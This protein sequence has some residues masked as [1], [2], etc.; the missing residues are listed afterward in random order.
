MNVKAQV[1][2]FWEAAAC[3][4]TYAVGSALRGQLEAQA[5]ARYELEPYLRPF[6]GFTDGHRK[7]VLEIGVGMGADHLAWAQAQPR[8][9]AGI[10]LTDRAVELTQARLDAAKLASTLAVADA[11]RLPFPDERF[12][13]IY[14]W[15]VL[16]H[17]PD[18]L[19]AFQEVY[20]VLRPAGV[21]RLMIYHRLSLTVLMLWLRYGLLR[22]RPLTSL[23]AICAEYLESPGTKAYSKAAARGLCQQAGFRNCQI[24]IQLNHGDLLQGAVGA[25]HQGALLAI[26][27]TFW[28]RALIRLLFPF[29][30]LYLLIEARK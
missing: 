29:L 15:G 8:L 10:D 19:K 18:T 20:R 21:A 9:L 14:S 13:L 7:A 28:P 23:A 26:A 6:A 30:G 22:G 2:E 17:S 12:D 25:R 11:E 5:A 16:H 4:E 24:R 3:G 1:R 27:K